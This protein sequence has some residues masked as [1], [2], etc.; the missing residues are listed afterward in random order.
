[1]QLTCTVCNKSNEYKAVVEYPIQC[2]ECNKSF[3][4]NGRTS[5]EA[6]MASYEEWRN[7]MPKDPVKPDTSR[8]ASGTGSMPP[9]VASRKTTRET[10][11]EATNKLLKTLPKEEPP[12]E[13]PS[14]RAET[15]PGYVRS[16]RARTIRPGNTRERVQYLALDQMEVEAIDRIQ[17]MLNANRDY[18]DRNRD[19][20]LIGI[21]ERL[22]RIENLV[23]F[24]MKEK[25]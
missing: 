1:M 9:I 19:I 14:T 8:I 2:V 23:V 10:F 15:Q 7:S 18:P 20:L 25:E 13:T 24:L 4:P 11:E 6:A 22:E 5:W 3:H 12:K 17:A 21:A 16:P